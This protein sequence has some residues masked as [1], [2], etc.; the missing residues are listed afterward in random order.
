VKIKLMQEDRRKNCR[1][2]WL[3]LSI[4]GAAFLLALLN[5]TVF[6]FSRSGEVF[7][8]FSWYVPLFSAIILAAVLGGALLVLLRREREKTC[9][10]NQTSAELRESRDRLIL[11]Q[12]A[13]RV[14]IFDWDV[15]T[16]KLIWSEQLE[17]LF[18]LPPGSFEGNYE[19]WAKRLHPDDRPEIES[20]FRQWVRER[21]RDIE[22]EHRFIRS[23]TAEVRWM[24]ISGRLSY[25]ADGTPARMIGTKV[26]ITE[27]KQAEEALR[28]AKEGLEERVKERTVELERRNQELQEFAFAASHDL[29]EPLR[30][31]QTFG[32][33]LKTRSE[34]RW[35]EKD[36]DYISRM[37]AAAERMQNL[38]EGLL[39]YSRVQTRAQEFES[40]KLD[41]VVQSNAGN[42]EESAEASAGLNLQAEQMH[43]VVREL[44]TLVNGRANGYGHG[45]RLPEALELSPTLS[46]AMLGP[47]EAGSPTPGHHSQDHL[48]SSSPGTLH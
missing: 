47:L 46:P 38:L 28:K 33:L 18:G 26:D 21:R 24:A 29:S 5:A 25:L 22:F 15:T 32:T 41:E 37:T 31:I 23:D 10:M 9:V 3:L 17:K 43:E 48:F 14:G 27:R 8:E 20:Q 30:K 6:L 1:K 39:R 36:K 16:G 42:A 11:A 12:Q 34:E 19:G 7:V 13:G 35:D 40:V 45:A 44:V 4:I 2:D